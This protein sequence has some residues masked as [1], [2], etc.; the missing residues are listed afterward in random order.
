MSACQLSFPRVSTIQILHRFE[1]TIHLHHVKANHL[2]LPNPQ[3]CHPQRVVLSHC[4]YG[5][6]LLALS[7][8]SKIHVVFAPNICEAPL[9]APISAEIRGDHQTSDWMEA[10]TLKK[11]GGIGRCFRKCS[12][13]IEMTGV[14]LKMDILGH[15][16][17]PLRQA[18]TLEFHGG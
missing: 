17:L 10:T 8:H 6:D 16:F 2:V 1:P 14:N 7:E 11:G 13:I 15:V 12:R 18:E 5:M 4:H 9:P 3:R